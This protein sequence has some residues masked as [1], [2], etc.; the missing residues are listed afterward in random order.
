[1]LVVSRKENE[2]ITIEP[3]EGVDPSLTLREAFA[4]GAI[5]VK[6]TH[7]GARRVRLLI[8]APK[9]LKIQRGSSSSAE[10]DPELPAAQLAELP[11]VAQPSR[12]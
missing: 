8:E 11:S 6:L 3:V 7:V 9:A 2:S 12:R 10:M 5:V 1:V 4:N